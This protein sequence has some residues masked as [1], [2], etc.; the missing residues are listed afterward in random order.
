MRL[1]HSRL[2][3]VPEFGLSRSTPT[4]RPSCEAA[5][6]ILDHS[7]YTSPSTATLQILELATF[8]R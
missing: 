7:C 3:N 1:L 5:G 6:S 8:L 2:P 4:A